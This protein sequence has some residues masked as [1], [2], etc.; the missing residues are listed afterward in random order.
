MAGSLALVARL[1]PES[2]NLRGI[3]SGAEGGGQALG[4]RTPL[5]RAKRFPQPQA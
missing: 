5:G 3:A 1:E 2:R 4:Q